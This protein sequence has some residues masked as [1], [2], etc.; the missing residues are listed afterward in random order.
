M[1]VYWFT[2]L[3]LLLGL[4]YIVGG[5]H[6]LAVYNPND[7]SGSLSK[8]NSQIPS[9]CYEVHLGNP[10]QHYLLSS[11][12]IET[13]RLERRSKIG[14]NCSFSLKLL[15]LERGLKV[16]HVTICTPP[17]K[18]DSVSNSTTAPSNIHNGCSTRVNATSLL[19]EDGIPALS[20]QQV[21]TAMANDARCR[22]SF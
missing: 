8:T 6:S 20:H 17:K 14:S 3:L 7:I 1:G 15:L 18:V 4:R 9:G 11:R 13:S 21:S 10:I 22:R 19:M 16:Y 12:E 2:I 5:E